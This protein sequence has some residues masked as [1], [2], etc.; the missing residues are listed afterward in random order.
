MADGKKLVHPMECK[1][2]IASYVEDWSKKYKHIVKYVETIE[3]KVHKYKVVFSKPEAELPVP[4][5]V[6]H[7]YFK[8]DT[9]SQS[10]TYQFEN[11]NLVHRPNLTVKANKME[12]WIDRYINDKVTV[13][14]IKELKTD[15]EATRMRAH[16]QADE[17]SASSDEEDHPVDAH[18]DGLG[19]SAGDD[20]SDE[21]GEDEVAL[22]NVIGGRSGRTVSF[23][24]LLGNIFA[25]ADEDNT[26]Y[27]PY[28]QVADLLYNTP[29]DLNDW[30]TRVLLS[31]AGEDENGMV[32]YSDFVRE[33]PMLADDLKVRR[34]MT[35][36]KRKK[37]TMMK[38]S[39]ERGDESNRSKEPRV[40]DIITRYEG[41]L[42]EDGA[43]A[44]IL[45]A[46]IELC[47]LQEFDTAA[48][49]IGEDF[50]AEE[51]AMLDKAPVSGSQGMT[52]GGGRVGG[53]SAQSQQDMHGQRR[54]C[55]SR[56]QLRNCMRAKGQYFSPQEIEMVMQTVTMDEDGQA[57]YQDFRQ[58]LAE[59]RRDARRYSVTE[60][61]V[62]SLRKH[63]IDV[64]QTTAVRMKGKERV[65]KSTECKKIL[66]ECS[67]LTLSRMDI[68]CILAVLPTD[69]SGLVR[70][71]DFVRYSVSLIH[72]FFSP[73][74]LV[75]TAREVQRQ[76]DE[77]AKA[78]QD[79]MM[80]GLGGVGVDAMQTGEENPEDTVATILEAE[81]ACKL[82]TN[83][84]HSRKIMTWAAFAEILFGTSESSAAYLISAFKESGLRMND[85]RAL[86]AEAEPDAEDMIQPVDTVE[87]WIPIIAEIRTTPLYANI[88]KMEP[89]ELEESGILL[90]LS[91]YEEEDVIA[92]PEGVDV[93]YGNNGRIN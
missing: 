35:I 5:A 14:Q 33:A 37:Q 77:E 12:M 81:Q 51:A 24:R 36:D 87:K 30:D 70:V 9:V 57:C 49:K 88:V 84:F 59:V 46:V 90:D 92:V 89:Q 62:S 53:S 50:E 7:V 64:V 3:G 28:M 21:D 17:D 2:F 20:D 16:A 67:Q 31:Y 42:E 40:N 80:Q 74:T 54:Y 32:A 79:H 23:D 91:Q 47:F 22:A 45:P 13:R 39:A 34:K 6:V 27:L 48:A 69:N 61:D 82:L 72:H 66:L 55:L 11:S 71:D 63:I 25:A 65:L 73:E 78:K 60:T 19:A 41:L 93:G 85:R 68:L 26:G 58:T 4:E 56:N 52:S 83:F 1:Q 86:V 38:L 43:F 18:N 8:F 10:M 29:L 76:R 15:F 44:E 75:A